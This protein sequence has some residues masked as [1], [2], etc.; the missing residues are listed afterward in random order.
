M[1]VYKKKKNLIIINYLK[2][3]K[4]IYNKNY[5]KKIIIGIVSNVITNQNF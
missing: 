4:Q 1:L 5:I 3:K 2:S